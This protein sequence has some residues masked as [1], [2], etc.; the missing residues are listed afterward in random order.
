MTS[1]EL[2]S[3]ESRW[4]A[5]SRGAWPADV[6]RPPRVGRRTGSR[7]PGAPASC[8]RTAPVADSGRGRR[9]ELLLEQDT[10]VCA[11][12]LV[13]GR[14][15]ASCCDR[16]GRVN[17]ISS[18]RSRTVEVAT[19]ARRELYRLP[20]GSVASAARWDGNDGACSSPGRLRRRAGARRC[21]QRL[22]LGEP[23]PRRSSRSPRCRSGSSSR[24]PERCCSM[25]ADPPEPVRRWLA[26]PAGSPRPGA[27]RR[28]DARP[29]AGV[30]AR[31]APGRL[32][33]RPL[34]EPR[35]LVARDRQRRH[36]PPHL[37]RRR[38][39]G[40][41][42]EPGRQTPALE[43][44]PRRS[45]RDL[46]RRARRHRR[47]PGDRRRSRRR[48]SD[49][50]GGRRLDRLLV[51]QS[52]GARDL[53]GPPRRPRRPARSSPA[54]TR[55][56]SSRR[57]RAG[58]RRSKRHRAGAPMR[59]VRLE[60]GAPVAELSVVPAGR[61]N[62]GDPLAAGRPDPRLLR[63]RRGPAAALFEQPI[64]PGRDTRANGE[65]WR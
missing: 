27:D 6:L 33:L 39:L 23:T 48:E 34:G 64:V 8:G 58:S 12:Q 3:I 9:G 41:A 24:G 4:S 51:E 13:A 21:L 36:A 52:G 40:S 35:P 47:A 57:S 59:I 16:R 28:A 26:G 46:D 31:R 55:C 49:D 37:R 62:P 2:T 45:L 44:E 25:P 20:A 14:P 10:A 30:L 60:D 19:G 22:E 7:S 54:T 32:H 63:R 15:A 18:S 17:T 43:L 29:P 1:P 65:W 38:R 53:E 56:R 50:V 11:S 61:Q 42:M 5:A